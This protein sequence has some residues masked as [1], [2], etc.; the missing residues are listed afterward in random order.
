MQIITDV[1]PTK[2]LEAAIAA[3]LQTKDKPELA[4]ASLLNEIKDEE[5]DDEPTSRP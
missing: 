5:R 1:K 2:E 3:E 4:I